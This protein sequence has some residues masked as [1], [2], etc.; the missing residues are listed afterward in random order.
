[1]HFIKNFIF[2]KFCSISYT[3]IKLF[4]PCLTL[5]A[6]EWSL[7]QQ[8]QKM[9]GA[10]HASKIELLVYLICRNNQIALK[11][12]SSQSFFIQRRSAD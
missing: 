5:S 4:P 1:M 8:N 3:R 7:K 9:M 10:V 11:L 6:A 12:K 2:E